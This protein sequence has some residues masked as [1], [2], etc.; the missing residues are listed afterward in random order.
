[1]NFIEDGKGTGYSAQVDNNHRLQ[2]KSISEG[3]NV[4][5]AILGDNYNINTGPITLT[6]DN[7][8]A[9]FYLKNG[10]EKDFII[11]EII[12]ILGTSTGGSG[13]TVVKII[14]N[15]TTGTIITNAVDVDNTENRN[16]GSSKEL[17]ESHICKGVEGDTFTDGVDFADTSRS[18]STT[19]NFDADVIILP[20][21]SSIGVEIEPATGNT[22]QIVRVAVV[23]FLF[24]GDS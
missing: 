6:S 3:F 2:V 24:N 23:G 1:M 19:V 4:E 20:K 9:V 18:G 10:E 22:N 21:S 14:K 8:S 17:A 16:F 13:D 7:N 12:A 15:P 11:T 5:A